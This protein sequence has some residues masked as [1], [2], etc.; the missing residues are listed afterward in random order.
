MFRASGSAYLLMN[1]HQVL[2]YGQSEYVSQFDM[3]ISNNLLELEARILKA[4]VL[5][6]HPES[7]QPRVELVRV[8]P[9]DDGM[10]SCVCIQD[11]GK[12]TWNL[13]VIF[14]RLVS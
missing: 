12:S 5:K 10:I 9:S 6:Y 2:E 1:C 3:N 7:V 13:Y 4:P 14:S 11:P 8:S